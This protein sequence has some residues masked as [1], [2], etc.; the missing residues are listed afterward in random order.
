MFRIDS[1]EYFRCTKQGWETD[2]GILWEYGGFNFY[3]SETPDGMKY[4][5]TEAKTGS[6]VYYDYILNCVYDKVKELVEQYDFAVLI[7]NAIET[8]GLS[9]LYKE[10]PMPD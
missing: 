6:L 4:Y 1:V 7:N 2:I 10:K 3:I 8:T 5:C 9:P